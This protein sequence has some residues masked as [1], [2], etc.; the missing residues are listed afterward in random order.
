MII[1]EDYF[2]DL[3]ITDEDIIEDNNLDVEEPK[4][5]LTLDEFYELPDQYNQVIIFRIEVDDDNDATFI[6]TTLIPKLFKRLDSIFEL[7]GIEHS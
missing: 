6:Q 4:H 7:Y 1:N 5:E 3:E 2:K